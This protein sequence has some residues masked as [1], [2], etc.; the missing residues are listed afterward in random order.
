M[1]LTVILLIECELGFGWFIP[2]WT[3]NLS[4]NQ[5]SDIWELSKKTNW[6]TNQ[7]LYILLWRKNLRTEKLL[8]LI[9]CLCLNSPFLYKQTAVSVKIDK[10]QKRKKYIY[11]PIKTNMVVISSGKIC[12]YHLFTWIYV[13]FTFLWML[14]YKKNDSNW[15][16]VYLFKIFK[17]HYLFNLSSDRL[18][19]KKFGKINIT[20][21]NKSCGY[22]GLK[23]K[24]ESM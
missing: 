5:I 12:R 9:I 15:S 1:F 20:Q 17:L 18:L 4:K 10:T 2:F 22:L 24:L 21:P 6:P 8:H 23:K 14:H 13:T 11:I 7:W 3:A 16:K 19:H